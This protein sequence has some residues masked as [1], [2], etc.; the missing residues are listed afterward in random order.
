MKNLVRVAAFAVCTA[1]AAPVSAQDFDAGSEAAQAGDYATAL[2]NW[3]P[4]AEQGNV[5][6]QY[7]LGLMHYNSWG[8][9]QD[10]AE[11]V[12]WYR[13]AAEQGLAIAQANLAFMYYQGHGTLQDYAEAM[14]WYRQAAEQGLADSQGRLGLMY[15]QGHGV[16]QDY[17]SAHMWLN[18]AS[19][20]GDENSG[21]ARDALADLMTPDQIAEAQARARVCMSSDYQDC[22]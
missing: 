20:N 13:Q 9:P 16:P 6:A 2:E 3:L 4:L 1:L 10:Y 12:R 17:A 14:R 22:D 8:V 11:A 18:I 19:A 15:Y 21:E 7:N 5:V